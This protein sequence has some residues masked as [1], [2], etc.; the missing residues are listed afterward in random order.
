MSTVKNTTPVTLTREQ[1]EATIRTHERFEGSMEEPVTG[2]MRDT[3]KG[4]IGS[5]FEDAVL[6]VAEAL[7]DLLV[8]THS[9]AVGFTWNP[10][11]TT[12]G[13]QVDIALP[14]G[15]WLAAGWDE[16]KYLT[17]DREATGIDGLVAIATH[18]IARINGAIT[19]AAP[20]IAAHADVGIPTVRDGAPLRRTLVTFEVLWNPEDFAGYSP[21]FTDLDTLS[22][23]G[24]ADCSVRYVHGDTQ[25]VTRPAMRALLEAQ[26]S[27][28]DFLGGACRYSDCEEDP[29][30]GDGWDGWC[31]THADRIAA[32]APDAGPLSDF[33]DRDDCP[34]C[35]GDL[36]A[37]D[38]PMSA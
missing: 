37:P 26:G 10:D 27:D 1:I 31:A 28:P 4:Y 23:V 38:E 30:D 16:L 22:T 7:S 24:A 34:V 11:H 5:D 32:H 13:A 6:D 20:L 25:K 14:D 3:Y 35:C 12:S 9:F 19:L 21:N 8:E 33:H 18:L 36:D 29:D 2:D 15:G 17:D